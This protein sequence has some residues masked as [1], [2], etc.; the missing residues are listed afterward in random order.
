MTRLDRYL[1]RQ[2]ALPF[3][4]TLLC[5]TAVVW[6]TQV[7]QRVD[8]MVEDGGSLIS[9]LRVT[10]LL[11][12]SLVGLIVPFALLAGVLYGLNVLAT[13]NEL[14]VIGAAGGSRLRIGRSVILLSALAS[15]LVLAVNLDLQPRSY[16]ML[17][18]TVQE[19][20]SDIA[21]SLIRSGVFTEAMNGVTIY[22]DE[23]RPGDQYIGLL[24]HDERDPV[25]PRTYT[26][27]SGLFRMTEA[28]PVLFLARGTVQRVDPGR[29]RVEIVRFM[30]TA[31]D[32][33]TF[34]QG[35]PDRIQEATERYVGELLE[36]D[37]S[38]PYDRLH[39]G[40][41]RAE[42]HARLAT[43][44]Y[45]LAFGMIATAALLTA[46]VSRQGH[47]RRLALA[48]VL[49]ITLRTFGFIL[50]NAAADMPALNPVQYLLPASASVLAF[51][52]LTG[53]FWTVRQRKA[54]A[55][56]Y[57]TATAGAPA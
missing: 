44:L 9:F 27:E 18:D 47:G 20:R 13:D 51:A 52:V 10:M 15:L 8:L 55:S 17:K 7:L 45:T 4:L 53:R 11:I 36:P 14:P 50:Q 37:M 46:P 34:E 40:S 39:A 54:A 32:L 25:E 3:F 26:A 22:A 33:A 1:F 48:L 42:G 12:P 56:R 49:A 19:V 24:I 6:L 29:D 35:P 28:G 43:P 41:L 2:T 31:V 38:E 5:T 21:R 30:E 16:R 57:S 23:V